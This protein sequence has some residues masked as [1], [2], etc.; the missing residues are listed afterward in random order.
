MTPELIGI[1]ASGVALATLMLT[2][3]GR[4]RSDIRALGDRVTALEN[5]LGALEQ[6]L[7]R[8][9]GLLKGAGLYR[10]AV[11]SAAGTAQSAA[12]A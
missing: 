11:A 7:A 2:S 10:P 4:L 12:G 6:R 3:T 5:R 8:L 9:E 1:I